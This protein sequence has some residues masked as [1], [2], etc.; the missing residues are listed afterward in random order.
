MLVERFM[1]CMGWGERVGW[2]INDSRLSASGSAVDQRVD[3]LSSF[4]LASCC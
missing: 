4:M 1:A 2:L 3:G